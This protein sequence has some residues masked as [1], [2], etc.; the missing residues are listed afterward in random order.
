MT[1][2]SVIQALGGLKAREI[3]VFLQSRPPFG[4]TEDD[5]LES[6]KVKAAQAIDDFLKV[7]F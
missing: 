7:W 4:L 3:A 5:P 6:Q 1:C 2:P